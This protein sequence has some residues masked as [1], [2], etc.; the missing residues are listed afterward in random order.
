MSDKLNTYDDFVFGGL[1]ENTRNRKNHLQK[2][3]QAALNRAHDVR[4]F[5]IE[6][7]W[8][9]NLY[10]WGFN[11][12]LFAAIGVLIP[13][14]NGKNAGLANF[15]KNLLLV[16]SL[17]GIFVTFAWYYV[18]KGSKSWQENWEKHI[19]YLEDGFTGRLHKAKIGN[20]EDFVSVSR[21][22]ASVIIAIGF[23]WLLGVLLLMWPDLV[24]LVQSKFLDK[25]IYLLLLLIVALILLRCCCWPT[26][27]SDLCTKCA[28]NKEVEM[29]VRRVPIPCC[30]REDK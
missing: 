15:P 18:H 19:D 22:N 13:S 30:K 28:N 23:I 14:L 25:P 10:F 9:R 7:Y 2:M 12:A 11:V 1:V 17:F 16:I 8:R 5:E 24:E 20:K 3:K 4:K 26:G 21:I 29:T 27:D 6:L